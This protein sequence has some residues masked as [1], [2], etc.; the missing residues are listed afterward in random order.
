MRDFRGWLSGGEFYLIKE[1]KIKGNR[2]G[3]GRV[4]GNVAGLQ[5]LCIMVD[6]FLIC[7]TVIFWGLWWQALLPCLGWNFFWVDLLNF[8]WSGA[9][10]LSLKSVF[11]LLWEYM[12]RGRGGGFS[13]YP[14]RWWRALKMDGIMGVNCIK[15]AVSGYSSLKRL[16]R[17]CKSIA[18]TLLLVLASLT[19]VISRHTDCFTTLTEAAISCSGNGRLNGGVPEWSK[20]SDCKSAGRCLRRFESFPLH[21]S[22]SFFRLI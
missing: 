15:R 12:P 16:K 18:D 7:A 3:T 20:G 21:H 9:L 8:F 13:R 4:A 11:F 19:Y 1:L 22:Q 5:V 14:R 6:L 10:E 17:P 2:R